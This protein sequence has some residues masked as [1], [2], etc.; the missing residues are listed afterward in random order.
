MTPPRSPD[1]DLLEIFIPLPVAGR[2]SIASK[3]VLVD[4]YI[5]KLHDLAA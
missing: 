5:V 4:V 2:A 3:D 1:G